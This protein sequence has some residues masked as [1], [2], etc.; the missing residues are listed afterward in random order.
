MNKKYKSAF[1]AVCPSES[2]V[3]RIFDMTKNRKVGLRLLIAVA[4]VSVLMVVS[5]VSV[6]AATDGMIVEE[7]EKLVENIRVFING[8]EAS[9]EDI[10]YTHSSEVVDGENVDRH[11]FD[12]DDAGYASFKVAEDELNIIDGNFDSVMIENGEDGFRAKIVKGDNTVDVAVDNDGTVSDEAYEEEFVP[13]YAIVA[14]EPS[15]E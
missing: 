14:S 3:E 7:A 15:E 1:N 13:D 4:V 5:L 8:E 6:N 10:G 11:S 12:F 9:A 2:S